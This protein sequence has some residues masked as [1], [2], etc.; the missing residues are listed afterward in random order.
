MCF[1]LCVCF[2]F[3]GVNHV[4]S[5]MTW[6]WSSKPL[7]C[8]WSHLVSVRWLWFL[9][10]LNKNKLIQC[11]P[12]EPQGCSESLWLSVCTHTCS[13][14]DRLVW[15]IWRCPSF[16]CLEHEN[17]FCYIRSLQGQHNLHNHNATQCAEGKQ[18]T[19]CVMTFLYED[20][21]HLM[22][23]SPHVCPTCD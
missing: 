2:P 17:L 10:M 1:R 5:C 20:M 15:F 22:V 4:L 6:H 16:N 21:R 9:G 12:C 18:W 11:H 13:E 14:S 23:L 7:W 3:W 19:A 8:A